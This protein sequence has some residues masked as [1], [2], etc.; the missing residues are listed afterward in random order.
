MIFGS[1]PFT[2]GLSLDLNF[3]YFETLRFNI[4]YVHFLKFGTF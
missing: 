4:L 3:V 1:T 2:G